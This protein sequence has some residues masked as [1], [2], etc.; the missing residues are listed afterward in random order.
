MVFLVIVLLS[1][2]SLLIIGSRRVRDVVY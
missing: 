2:T 1:V